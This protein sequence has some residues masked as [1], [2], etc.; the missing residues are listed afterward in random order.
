MANITLRSIKGSPL[1]ISEVDTNFSNLNIEVGQKLNASTYTPSDILT[2][3]KTVDGIGSGLDA[4]TVNGKA[5]ATTNTPSTVV[6]RDGTGNFAANVITA[7]SFVGPSVGNL[8]GNVT[9]DL[10]GNASNALSLGGIPAA[11]YA[12]LASPALLGTPTAPTATPGTST[13][14]IATTAFTMAAVVAATGSLG[15]MSIQ[16]SNNVSITGGSLS[17]VL[18]NTFAVGSN[19]TGTKTVSTSAPT[20]G[21]DGDVWYQV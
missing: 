19:A 5:S 13:T 12:L 6:V 3:L 14:Q 20:G 7:T 2:K 16:N 18:I 9:G 1:T 10:T 17:N 11:S 4:D 8:T 21:N 15:T